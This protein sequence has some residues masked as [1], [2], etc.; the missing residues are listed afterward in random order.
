MEVQRVHN[1][2]AR[3]E[4]KEVMISSLQYFPSP[5]PFFHS[6][7]SLR[8]FGEDITTAGKEAV[9]KKNEEAQKSRQPETEEVEP[10]DADDAMED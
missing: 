9:Q 8:V 2:H 7:L 5:D 1:T 4:V 10:V 6:A 3:E